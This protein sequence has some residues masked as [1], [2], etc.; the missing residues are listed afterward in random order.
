MSAPVASDPDPCYCVVS[1][2]LLQKSSLLPSRGYFHPGHSEWSRMYQRAR[3]GWGHM[4]RVHAHRTAASRLPMGMRH[5]VACGDRRIGCFGEAGAARAT[6]NACLLLSL[7]GKVSGYPLLLLTILWPGSY[8]LAVP[9]IIY[10]LLIWV[11]SK[12][13]TQHR[14]Q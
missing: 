13:E 8:W 12:R 3:M 10:L 7:G 2:L 14:F 4:G 11:K 1:W 6:G 5:W 9:S